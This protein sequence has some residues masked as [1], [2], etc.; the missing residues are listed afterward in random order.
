MFKALLK[1]GLKKLN[2]ELSEDK[3]DKLLAYHALLAKWYFHND[4]FAQF[5]Q[6]GE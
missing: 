6:A 3:I 1:T 2:I 5:L 4:A